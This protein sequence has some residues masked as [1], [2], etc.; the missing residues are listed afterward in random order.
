[1]NLNYSDDESEEAELSEAPPLT[2]V[3]PAPPSASSTS[4]SSTE[5]ERLLLPASDLQLVTESEGLQLRLSSKASTGYVGVYDRCG[6]FAA[7]H[8]GTT[9]GKFSTALEAAKCRARYVQGMRFEREEAATPAIPDGSREI[10]NRTQPERL[11]AQTL[12]APAHNHRRRI[13]EAHNEED[14]AVRKGKVT[15]MVVGQRVVAQW[16]VSNDEAWFPGV[17]AA[18]HAD[19]RIDVSYDDGD[20]EERKDPERVTELVTEADGLKLHLSSGGAS[21]PYKWV[22]KTKRGKFKVQASG[23]G[24]NRHLGI[25]GTAVEAATCYARHVQAKRRATDDGGSDAKRAKSASHLQNAAFYAKHVLEQ[26]AAA[27][28]AASST[29]ASE[30]PPPG[31][32]VEERVTPAGRQYKLYHSGDGKHKSVPSLKAAWAAHASL[33]EDAPALAASPPPGLTGMAE[34]RALLA[35]SSL[36][37]YAE[38]LEELGYD[39]LNFLQSLDRETLMRI[40]ADAGIV[41]PGH[42]ARFRA[43]VLGEAGR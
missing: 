36:E 19:G 20:S 34:V 29:P 31:W 35:G 39:D 21:T 7:Q 11:D 17:V 42:V 5:S 37:R 1:M 15:A 3:A 2:P 4:S 22:W 40:A 23:N 28:A 18:V 25:F 38:A 43:C 26:S 12:L 13:T 41:K 32:T 24:G 6:M 33:Q 9:L 16:G 30:G 14:A 10:R 8:G 27:P